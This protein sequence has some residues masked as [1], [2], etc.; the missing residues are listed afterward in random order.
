[1]D[2]ISAVLAHSMG[3][4]YA[5]GRLKKNESVEG[6]VRSS[7]SVRSS[8]DVSQSGTQMSAQKLLRDNLLRD[9]DEQSFQK[10]DRM[11]R[12]AADAVSIDVPQSDHVSP[13]NLGEQPQA[14]N[15]ARADADAAS[16]SSDQPF[17]YRSPSYFEELQ[18]QIHSHRN[19]STAVK[20]EQSVTA[21]VV[22]VERPESSPDVLKADIDVDTSSDR[23][24]TITARFEARVD[25]VRTS[26]ESEDDRILP[27]LQS[28]NK[29]VRAYEA[30][31][32]LTHKAKGDFFS[33]DAFAQGLSAENEDKMKIA[34]ELKQFSKAMKNL[35]TAL[36]AKPSSTGHAYG[37]YAKMQSTSSALSELSDL[38]AFKPF[39]ITA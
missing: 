18:M 2:K 30:Q 13:L 1:M 12:G 6:G 31:S 11:K 33:S 15:V 24:R 16:G 4:G 28:L 17:I 36:S 35:T 3:R 21:A 23:M 25:E 20:D 39:K 26:A 10:I 14:T 27:G 22:E 32:K 8:G 5:Y 9:N 34:K 38:P 37:Y 7:G 29:A 19:Q